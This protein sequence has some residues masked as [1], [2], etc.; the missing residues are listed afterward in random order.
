MRILHTSDWHIGRTLH[1]VDLLEYHAAYFDHL[2]D[3]VVDQG[4]DAVLVSGDIY[5]RAIP[6]V[7]AVELL[8]HTLARLTEHSHVILTPGNHDSAIRLGFGA[9]LMRSNLHIRTQLKNITTPV[10]LTGE[11]DETVHVYA[12]PYLDPDAARPHLTTDDETPARSHEAVMRAA[13]DRIRAA[14]SSSATHV[15]MI[16][17]AHA[18][19]TGGEPSESERDIRVGGVDSIRAGVFAGIDYGALGHLHGPQQVSTTPHMRYSGSPLAFSFSEMNHKKSTVL[20]DM[21]RTGIVGEPTLIPAPVPRKLHELTG[22]MDELLD[23]RTDPHV[24]D[25]LRIYVT[26]QQRPHDMN[27][28]LKKRFPHALVMQHTPAATDRRPKESI[29]VTTHTN[30]SDVA[31]QF[32]TEV[33]DRSPSSEEIAVLNQALDAVRAAERSA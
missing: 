14:H 1:G 2:V 3:L 5:D 10:A 17:M 25:W 29:L 16:V 23:S 8:S 20:L 4:V 7:D 31:V 15:P 30:P 13:M 28:T 33:T 26:D 24:N 19:V 18:F 22:T 12:L 32:V 21:D 6:P 9:H 11:H 27:A